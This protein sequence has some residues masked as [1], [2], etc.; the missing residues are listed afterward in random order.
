MASVNHDH[1]N[2]TS[3]GRDLDA[4]LAR[5]S[6]ALNGKHV[7]IEAR[8]DTPGTPRYRVNLNGQWSNWHMTLRAAVAE[9][10]GEQQ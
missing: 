2:A 6:D 10:K 3:L 7:R 1:V 5:L 4:F 8:L 9:W